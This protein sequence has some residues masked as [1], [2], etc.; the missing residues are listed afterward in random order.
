MLERRLNAEE[1]ESIRRTVKAKY[2]AV[3]ER[4][5]ETFPYPVGRDSALNL[6]YERR[7]IE[8]IP[9]EVVERFVGV[10]NPFTI[11]RPRNGERVLDVGCGCG[12]DTYVASIL[13]GARGT[14]VG[15]DLTPEMLEVARRG[16]VTWTPHN[17]EF[18]EGSAEQLPFDDA[19]FDLVISN[20]ALNLVPDKDAAF[21]ELSRVL[22]LGGRL[23]MADVLVDERIPDEVLAEKDAWSS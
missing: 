22:R 6:G 8:S 18:T 19:T 23:V 15:V 7:W 16:L 13:V 1:E 2:R 20:G 11:D 12:F 10:G 9:Q 5:Q 17:I 4:T 14:A 21:R 3:A